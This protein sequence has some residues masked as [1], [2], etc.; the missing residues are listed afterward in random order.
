MRAGIVAAVAAWMFVTPALAA[1]DTF[2]ERKTLDA[3]GYTIEYSAG[4]EPYAKALAAQL[5]LQLSP[6]PPATH[7]PLSVQDLGTRRKEVLELIGSQLALP[8]TTPKMVQTFDAFV[9]AN[10]TLQALWTVAAPAHFALWRKPELGARLAAG[11]SIAG[12]KRTVDG[13][14]DFTM[15]TS[16]QFN[17][18]EPAENGMKRMREDWA[19]LVWPLKIGE[20]GAGAPRRRCSRGLRACASS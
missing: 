16:F 6:A 1:P 11:Q 17:D 14:I 10:S 18:G 15:G 12:F 7:I 19:K 8:P 5:P 3:P 9:A 20:P 4:D 13:G 2:P